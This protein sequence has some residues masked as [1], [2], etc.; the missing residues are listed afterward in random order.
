MHTF[1][2]L[3]GLGMRPTTTTLSILLKALAH[4]QAWAISLQVINDAPQTFHI[5]PETRLFVQ[6]AQACVKARATAEV[7]QIFDAMLTAVRRRSER[8][9]PAMVSRLLRSCVLSGDHKVAAKLR[10]AAQQAGIAVEA[11]I[12]K[13]MSTSSAKR[14]PVSMIST[15]PPV[16]A[17]A[18]PVGSLTSSISGESM[19]P[20]W[21]KARVA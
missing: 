16:P 8:V 12:E 9:D 13:M 20:P 6:L 3:V 15:R 1:D 10:E 17:K 19:R 11:H 2:T 21:M 4:T 5:E 14:S 7:M 18:S